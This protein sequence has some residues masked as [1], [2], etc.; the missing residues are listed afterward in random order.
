[1]TQIPD[2]GLRWPTPYTDLN[3]VLAEL[4]RRLRAELGDTLIGVYLQGSF[5]VGDFDEASD[6]DMLFAVERDLDVE[7]VARLDALH[8]AVFALPIRWAKHIE[9]SYFPRA[10]LRRWSSMPRDPPGGPP[11]SD[12]WADPGTGAPPRAYPL[13]YLNN[14]ATSLVR[15]EH[16]N[17]QVVR[18][19]T[20][21]HGI[22]LFGPPALDLI[23]IV[24][25][26]A[27]KAEV[28]GFLLG[29]HP[30]WL[31]DPQAM[32]SR[33]LPA[34][35]VTWGCRVLQTLETGEVRSKKAATAW[36]RAAL[37]PSWTEAIDDAWR[38]SREPIA[39]RLL[40]ADSAVIS[41]AQ[42][43]LRHATALAG[44]DGE[45]GHVR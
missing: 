8:A 28:R 29:L 5:A 23:D 14:G 16:D 11:R 19:V 26:A 38:V 13:L 37:D 24:E 30:K 17:T 42:A 33:W 1:M 7:E 40:P 25:P 15:S 22:A 12:D 3:Q 2:F 6:V 31:S 44:G 9:G 27:L 45:S 41:R 34:F 32:E 10:I 4:T 35:F 20:R 21:Q 18:W 43:F 36:G 39:D